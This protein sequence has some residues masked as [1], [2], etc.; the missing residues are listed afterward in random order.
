MSEEADMGDSFAGLKVEAATPGDVD[1]AG[2]HVLRDPA[3][4]KKE[5]LWR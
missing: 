4:K 3:E 2:V 5:R 1:P